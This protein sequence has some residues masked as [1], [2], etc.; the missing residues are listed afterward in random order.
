MFESGYNFTLLI[1]S[2]ER[3]EYPLI[4]KRLYKFK[5]LANRVYH[6]HIHEYEHRVFVLKFHLKIDESDRLRFNKTLNDFDTGRVLR[7]V[8][9]ISLS[10]LKEEPFASFAFV[11]IFKVSSEDYK[12]YRESRE[13]HATQRF[14]IYKTIAENLLGTETFIHSMEPR[15]SAYLLINKKNINSESL[16]EEVIDMFSKAFQDIYEIHE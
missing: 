8:I 12:L 7:T 15:I 2:I 14:R 1:S 11:G 13:T 6:V 9:D 4:A 16:I 10:I 3:D 5:T